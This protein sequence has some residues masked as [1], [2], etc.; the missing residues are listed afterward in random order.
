LE[1]SFKIDKLFLR[2]IKHAGTR[3]EVSQIPQNPPA[4]ARDE[5]R[6]FI[7]RKKLRDPAGNAGKIEICALLT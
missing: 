6:I 3:R 2:K 5:F 1:M 7:R 4:T